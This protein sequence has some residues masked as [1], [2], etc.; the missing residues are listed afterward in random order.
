[1]HFKSK[2]Y[3]FL[4]LKYKKLDYWNVKIYVYFFLLTKFFICTNY[5]NTKKSK[6]I[7]KLWIEKSESN[8]VK[9]ISIIYRLLLNK[10]E[11][12]KY[13]KKKIAWLFHFNHIF[14]NTNFD[15]NNQ[16]SKKMHMLYIWIDICAWSSCFDTW[17]SLKWKPDLARCM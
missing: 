1:M 12:K 11:K 9:L 7:F 3:C 6:T 10:E 15:C 5:S 2:K 16:C 13:K 8:Q 4:P 14:K 17:L